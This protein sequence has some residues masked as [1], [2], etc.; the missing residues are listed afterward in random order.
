M[1]WVRAVAT[2]RASPALASQAEK[3]SRRTGE[4]EKL[5]DPSWRAQR[6]SAINKESIIPSKHKRAD[7]RWVR[8]NARPVS[9]S[10]KADEKVKWTGVIRLLWTQTTSF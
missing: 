4:A 6:E 8:L 5:V 7:S 1:P 9:P 10:M 2:S 3:A